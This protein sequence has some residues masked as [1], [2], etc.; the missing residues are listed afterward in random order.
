MCVGRAP[1]LRPRWGRLLWALTAAFSLVA[2]GAGRAAYAA[3]RY[4]PFP[5][6]RKTRAFCAIVWLALPLRGRA[7][8][9]SLA[10]LL[11]GCGFAKGS[12]LRRGGPLQFARPSGR[13]GPLLWR[14]PPDGPPRRWSGGLCR[15]PPPLPSCRYAAHPPPA[16]PCPS[17]R[18]PVLSA[19]LVV[20]VVS[21]SL[22]DWLGS[23]G[24]W[25][26]RPCCGTVAPRWPRS[27]QRVRPAPPAVGGSRSPLATRRPL[28]LL[29]APPADGSGRAP[30]GLA[31][32]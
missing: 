31:P 20:G 14:V 30:A 7:P 27:G 2:G 18:V 13:A 10:P 4:P 12:F 24:L 6:W 17:C 9:S 26:L 28:R 23:V 29:P 19:R 8:N 22:S 1:T 3:P 11:R 16:C 25:G 32:P 15:G 21:R 5:L